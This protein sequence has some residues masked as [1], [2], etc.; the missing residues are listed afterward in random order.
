MQELLEGSI[1]LHVHAAPGLA[2]RYADDQELAREATEAKRGGFALKAHEGDTT[3]RVYHLQKQFPE[4]SI[5]GGITLNPP[6][7]GLNPAAVET[8]LSLHGK[9]VWFPTMYSVA[10]V[11]HLGDTSGVIGAKRIPGREPIS[12]LTESGTLSEAVFDILQL[13]KSHDAVLA[14]GHV[15][16][17]ELFQLVKGAHELGILRILINHPEYRVPSLSMAEQRELISLGAIVEKCYL[18]TFPTE[19]V[20]DIS[21]MAKG[22]TELGPEHCV[23]VTDFGQAAKGSPISGMN[24]FASALL[25]EGLTTDQ[26]RLMAETNPRRLMG[27]S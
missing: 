24:D 11:E 5:F 18:A 19:G 22:I 21:D 17:Q 6:V 15:G 1:D 8:S 7:G 14:T 25:D 2:P 10:H 23:L 20:G 9:L 27:L 13:I 3:A 12:L 16:G 4:L 26:I